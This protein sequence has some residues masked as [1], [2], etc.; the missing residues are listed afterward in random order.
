MNV[1]RSRPFLKG[2]G[3]TLAAC[4][5]CTP[6]DGAL[7]PPLPATS[8]ARPVG[9]LGGL[10]RRGFDLAPVLEDA[11]VD[12]SPAPLDRPSDLAPAPPDAQAP[13]AAIPDAAAPIE[14]TVLP[15]RACTVRLQHP[16]R[17]VSEVWVAGDFTRW[18][19]APLPMVRGPDGFSIVLGPE[20]GLSPGSVHAY[21]LIVD[22]RWQ[23]DREQREQRY[24]G[25]CINS[26]FR[27]PDCE[28]RPR[29]EV[30]SI[31][32]EAGRLRARLMAEAATVGSPLGR[33]V[34]KLDGVP[35]VPVPDA[36]IE[37]AFDLAIDAVAPGRH[38]LT[39]G[40]QD[41]DGRE[42][43]N[44]RLA[45]W[46]EAQAFDWRDATLY[47]LLID[48]FANGARL[49]DGPVRGDVPYPND[50]HGGDLEGARAAL[51]AG[52]FEAL[53]INAIW[54]SPVNM[55]AE[56]GWPGR[57]G[58]LPFT[59][60]HGYWPVS[61][62]EVEPRF[63]GNA[64]LRDFVTAAHSRGIRVLLDL[65]NNQ[66]HEDHVYNREH[67]EW[68]R[69]ACVCGT[70]GCGW[71]ERPLD[72]LFAPYLPDIN[73]RV[74]EAEARF[75]ADAESWVEDYDVDGFR[76][77]AVKHV[78]TTA[79]YNLRARL[80]ERFSAPGA[81]RIGLFGETAVGEFD[82]FDD[83]CGVSYASGY[84]WISAYAASGG[85]DGQFDFPTHHRVSH[86]LLTGE[87]GLDSV[88]R[89]LEDARDRYA[90]DAVHVRFLGSHD[91][92][93]M[94]SRAAFDSAA[95]CRFVSGPP[96]EN[97]PGLTDDEAV[98]T[99]LRRA[100]TLLY[101]TPGIPLLYYG[102]EVAL[103]GGNDP[104]NRRD[105]TF[106][107][108]LSGLDMSG[109]RLTPLQ[110]G[111]RSFMSTLGQVRRESVALRR[112]ALRILVREP[113]VLVYAREVDSELAVIVL[114]RGNGEV[115]R[116]VDL[117]LPV[118]TTRVALGRGSVEGQ[119]GGTRLRM[120]GEAAVFLTR[121]EP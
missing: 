6:I 21:K 54:L 37:G 53:G 89:A 87:A 117:R 92:N 23:L 26:A 19:D 58:P 62:R 85:L 48:R 30:V 79:V 7:P 9:D 112:G 104:D 3:L 40:L 45:V 57:D 73:W 29:L 76:V 20:Q 18:A 52:Y 82:R 97:L 75:I 77:D 115:V 68:F 51:E 94:A 71:S 39:V 5:G 4:L 56:N 24:E 109:E 2:L 32:A 16:L 84:E 41:D 107:A 95:D 17:G 43:V 108:A 80:D 67:P 36:Q 8:D 22:G 42:A 60:Y 120:T 106:D 64:A 38:V 88:G 13:D 34:V 70:D 65:I 15:R 90:P 99:R 102:D 83:G 74:P 113:D 86:G 96:C 46:V 35:I 101:T 110:V 49:N 78:E 81:A 118:E 72:C 55:Q 105:M 93:R 44:Q 31:D 25:D 66:V 100:M 14:S 91:S 59:G 69:T 121:L 1:R 116:D 114:Q 12:A 11:H 111:H 28:T 63:G 98:T 103:A 119:A 33:V 50:W 61:A 10:D 47:M 27:V